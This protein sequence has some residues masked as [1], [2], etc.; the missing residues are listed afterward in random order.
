MSF[1]IIYNEKKRLSRP[2]KQKVQTVEQLT[3]FKRV[4]VQKWSFFQF[5]FE[6]N[7]DQENVFFL[8]F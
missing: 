4:L 1:T 7:I 6:G 8:I 3:F 5:F 2:L